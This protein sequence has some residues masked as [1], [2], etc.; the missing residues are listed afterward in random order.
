MKSAWQSNLFFLGDD[1]IKSIPKGYK[2]NDKFAHTYAG[3]GHYFVHDLAYLHVLAICDDERARCEEAQ[4]EFEQAFG[5]IEIK[6]EKKENQAQ[7]EKQV[8]SSSLE[9]E[10]QVPSSSLEKEKPEDNEGVS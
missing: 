8:P 9:E 4:K 10:K 6:E 2:F 7:E 3:Y 5:K 1:A